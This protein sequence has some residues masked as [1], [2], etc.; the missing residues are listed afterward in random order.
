MVAC[1]AWQHKM[2]SD[3]L[4]WGRSDFKIVGSQVRVAM[5]ACSHPCMYEFMYACSYACI[6][7]YTYIYMYLF[8]IIY[9]Y[10]YTTRSSIYKVF[11]FNTYIYMWTMLTMNL[12]TRNVYACKASH[13]QLYACVGV[14]VCRSLH[15]RTCLHTCIY[16]YILYVYTQIRTESER[17]GE[18]E[19]DVCVCV[20]RVRI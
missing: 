16:I 14:C 18:R 15:N 4:I 9:N 8:I 2:M 1:S 6:Y 3:K 19:R 13:D 11:V 10:I 12:C 5:Y 7:V 20:C 17:E